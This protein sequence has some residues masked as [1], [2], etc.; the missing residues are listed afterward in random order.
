MGILPNV[1]FP[2]GDS[3]S[4]RLFLLP[5]SIVIIIGVCSILHPFSFLDRYWM[6]SFEALPDNKFGFS[7]E[8]TSFTL[9]ESDSGAEAVRMEWLENFLRE[10]HLCGKGYEIMARTAVFSHQTIT[11]PVHKIYYL[12][13]CK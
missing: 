11:G 7:A 4:S 10:C 1:R 12:G 13:K 5:I 9:S 3:Q 2:I 8:T 6:S